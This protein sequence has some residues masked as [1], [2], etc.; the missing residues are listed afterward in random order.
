[1]SMPTASAAAGSDTRSYDGDEIAKVSHEFEKGCGCHELCYAQFDVSEINQF[2]L[3][4]K[5]L[6]K[7][8]RDMFLMGKL[9]LLARDPGTVVHARSSN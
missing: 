9:Q 3:S 5:E 7:T 8:E 1:M 6:E 4:M 2:R